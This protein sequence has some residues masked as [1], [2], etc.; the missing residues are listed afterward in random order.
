MFSRRLYS[1]RF[2]LVQ[3][4]RTQPWAFAALSLGVAGAFVAAF[5]LA[6][7]WHRLDLVRAELARVNSTA[8]PTSPVS[9]KP[10]QTGLPEL[11]PFASAPLV[12]TL[13][14][15]AVESGLVLEEV[16]Y[17]LDD[18]AGMPY[19]RY[20]I[21]LSV[22]ASYPLVRRLAER[23]HANVPNLMIDAIHCARKDVLMPD[24]RCELALSG[25]FRKEVARG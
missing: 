17:A 11:P 2:Q 6:I 22:N 8:R 23:L 10:L 4:M 13:N 20:R 21:T 16:R 15:T 5:A 19:L 3:T 12:A 1:L 7:Q 24:L 25:L 9:K 18:N 14:D